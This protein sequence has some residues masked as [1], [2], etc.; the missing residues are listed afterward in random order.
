M[1]L[2]FKSNVGYKRWNAYRAI[3]GIKHKHNQKVII[4]GHIH[5]VKH[6]T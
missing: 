4:K 5:K 2:H 1:V 6:T 3:H